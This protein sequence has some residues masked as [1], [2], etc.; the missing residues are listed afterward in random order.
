MFG[1][2]VL[3]FLSFLVGYLDNH[4]SIILSVYHLSIP[5]YLFIATICK[6]MKSPLSTALATSH[7]LE[8]KVLYFK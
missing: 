6:A 1:L 3:F 4:H 2:T 5:L 7:W 8:K